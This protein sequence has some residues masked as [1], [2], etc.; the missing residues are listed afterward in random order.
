MLIILCNEL[1]IFDNI[2][3]QYAGDEDFN[4]IWLQCKN[5]EKKGDFHIQEGYLFKGNQLCIPNISLRPQ[6]IKELYEEGIF[7]HDGHDKTISLLD[8]K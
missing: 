7:A 3:S 2:P 6:L 8:D 4:S 5:F 1:I